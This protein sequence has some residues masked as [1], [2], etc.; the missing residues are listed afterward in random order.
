MFPKYIW[1]IFFTSVLYML[2]YSDYKSFEKYLRNYYYENFK[3][4]SKENHNKIVKSNAAEVLFT[5]SALKKYTN[6]ND[7]LYL[8]ILGQ[9]FDV[10]K[11]AKHYGPGE[12]YHAF[13]G[14]D[15]SAAFI[16]GDFTENGLTDDISSLTNKQIQSLITWLEF[17]RKTYIYKGKLIGRYYNNDGNPTN[18]RYKLEEKV[19]IGKKS[20][21]D[22]EQKKI[23]YPPC[24]IEWD[25]N[26]G[27]RVWCTKNSGGI[28]RN[29]I[30]AP[31]MLYD[32]VK[33]KKYRCACIRLDIEFEEN[34]FIIKQYEGCAENATACILVTTNT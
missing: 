4:V 20:D 13:T 26:T 2:Y 1:L 5:T 6:L 8:S 21:L 22:E 7:G 10:T 29:W 17:Y 18:E 33:S 3:T 34:E 25:V 31:R 32:D 19:Q 12:T 15:G 11:G 9:V 16:T 30:G 27:T 23:K 14:R 28:A 24:N